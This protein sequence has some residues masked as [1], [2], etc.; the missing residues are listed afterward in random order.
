MGQI[1]DS[2]YFYYLLRRSN[3]L[4]HN[5]LFGF[6]KKQHVICVK[7]TIKII[8]IEQKFI[9]INLQKSMFISLLIKFIYMNVL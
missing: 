8:N 3:N 7:S 1:S 4:S 5:T 6:R 9:E 2:I